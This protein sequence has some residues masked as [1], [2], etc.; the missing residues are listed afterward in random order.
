[1]VNGTIITSNIN[2]ISDYSINEKT[3]YSFSPNDV[4]GFTWA[5]KELYFNLE[6]REK[7]GLYNK[8]IV[9][10][11]DICKVHEIMESLYSR[12]LQESSR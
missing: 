12:V 8:E 9:K 7:Y 1:M 11:F 4:N 3:G 10:K 6:L 5:I 2:G